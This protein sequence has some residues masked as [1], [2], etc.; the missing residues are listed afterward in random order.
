MLLALRE[1]VIL[2]V[3]TSVSFLIEVLSHPDFIEGKTHTGFLE[4]HGFMGK[5]GKERSLPD[6]VL[7]AAALFKPRKSVTLGGI[8]GKTPSTTPWTEIGSWQVGG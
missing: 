1:T 2:G 7:I 6:E 8:E 3:D 4:E 5:P